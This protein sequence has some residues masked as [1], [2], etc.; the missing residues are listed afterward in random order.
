[1]KQMRNMSA[2]QLSTSAGAC[3]SFERLSSRYTLAHNK[4]LQNFW[5]TIVVCSEHKTKAISNKILFFFLAKSYSQII[6]QNSV[7]CFY[8][9]V[10]YH[11]VLTSVR[12]F[13]RKI[14]NYLPLEN[15]HVG[16]LLCSVSHRNPR[17]PHTVPYPW[18]GYVKCT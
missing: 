8:W 15:E 14:N 5:F 11:V 10:E 9:V 16:E 2:Q 12:R 13:C 6:S 3:H 4:I 7:S 18:Y 1:M 17:N